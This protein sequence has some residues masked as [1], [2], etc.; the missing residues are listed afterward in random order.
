MRTAATFLLMAVSAPVATL[1]AG[2]PEFYKDVL[3]VLQNKCQ[4]CHRPGEIGPMPLV[5][6]Q[7]ARP[8]A[9]AI[10]ETALLGRMPPWFA[11]SRDGHFSNDW[12]LSRAEIDTLATWADAGAPMGQLA[13]APPPRQF[14]Q[15]WN[16]GQPDFVLAMP[17]AHPVP[18]EG[19]IDYQYIIVPT[20]LAE[21]RWVERV[22]VR[23]SD[24]TVVHH[25][26]IFIREPGSKWLR[27]A[28]PGVSVAAG[29]ESIG[30]MGS[31]I[32]SIYTPGM[33]PD[34]WKPGQA[35]LLKAGSDL[36]F[37][38][39]YTAS[40]KATVDQTRIGLRF[41]GSLPLERVITLAPANTKFAIP[42]GDP[43]YRVDATLTVPNPARLL[44][45][46]P[47]M[48][49][50]GKAFE[51]R[52][53]H[54]GG[55][56]QTLLRVAPYKFDW[57]LSYK[58]AEAVPLP[59]GS[60]IEMSAWFDN[61]PNNPAN[62]DANATVRWGEQSWEEMMIGFLDLAIDASMDRREFFRPGRDPSNGE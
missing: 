42:P 12:S 56:E 16:I 61:S 43:N 32:L 62:P 36:V 2:A 31:E 21:D 13:D 15:G 53:R 54:T 24:R 39:H 20:G 48:H 38:M 25:C 59:P 35:K 26:V 17:S 28:Q 57:Q 58:L 14:V 49:V 51:Y 19:K 1:S 40:G 46:F 37:Q 30:G 44:S 8:W 34:I 4:E 47:H 41:A 7:Q 3:P 10:K 6:Y 18:A 22:E 29:P 60:R 52:L 9:K 23:P 11:D 45:F 33:V 5:T 55:K 27:D 50:R